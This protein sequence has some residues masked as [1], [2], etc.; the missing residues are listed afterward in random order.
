M[1]LWDQF[2][3]RWLCGRQQ[4]QLH[5]TGPVLPRCAE[6]T[7]PIRVL[8]VIEMFQQ[9]VLDDMN[10]LLRSGEWTF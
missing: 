10:V 2:C 6:L 3:R 9:L 4:Q 5:T 8:S 7:G 1:A